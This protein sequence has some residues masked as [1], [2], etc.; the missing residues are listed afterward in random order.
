MGLW[1]KDQRI[2]VRSR[3][4]VQDYPR[5]YLRRRIF[6]ARFLII[7][8]NRTSALRSSIRQRLRL[9]LIRS[10][11]K[12]PESPLFASGLLASSDPPESLRG[13]FSRRG[14][15]APVSSL[16]SLVVVVVDVN[17]IRVDPR[18]PDEILGAGAHSLNSICSKAKSQRLV[19][20]PS[21]PEVPSNSSLCT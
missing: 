12:L 5:H 10:Y 14:F 19:T 21:P 7:G 9:Y 11:Q 8:A 17:L 18:T 2:C 20:R 13:S 15:V 6:L 1:A 3:D 16:P 4:F